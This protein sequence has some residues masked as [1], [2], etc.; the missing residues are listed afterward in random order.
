MQLDE[1]P[2]YVTESL[3]DTWRQT[4]DAAAQLAKIAGSAVTVA[5]DANVVI[6]EMAAT[7][8]RRAPVDDVDTLRAAALKQNAELARA[9]AKVLEMG[10]QLTT[11]RERLEPWLPPPSPLQ[12]ST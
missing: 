6:A 1:L 11:I 10:R 8:Q 12:P 4:M 7:L 5:I 3:V 2:P 9:S